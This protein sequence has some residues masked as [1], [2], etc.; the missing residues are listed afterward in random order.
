MY[1]AIREIGGYK[2]GDKVPSD[3]AK[4][5]LGMY[6]VPQVEKVGNSD[7]PN[8]IAESPGNVLDDYLARNKNVVK[9]NIS[10]DDL[11]QAQLVELLKLEKEGKNRTI[12]I[13]TIENRLSN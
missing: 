8:E 13:Q 4:V 6:S 9:K 1:K 2:I 7:E 5:W 11:N 12:I 10:E 3:K